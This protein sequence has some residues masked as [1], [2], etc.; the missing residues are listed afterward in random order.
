MFLPLILSK[1]LQV[2]ENNP[3]GCITY[4]PV[5]GPMVMFVTA[6][7]AWVF[8]YACCFNLQDSMPVQL[9]FSVIGFKFYRYCERTKN[10]QNIDSST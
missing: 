4:T 1:K 10:I 8:P 5:F 6:F 3:F 7:K 9:S 2:L